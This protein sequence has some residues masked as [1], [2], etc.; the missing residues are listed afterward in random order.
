MGQ[1]LEPARRRP[2]TLTA[3]ELLLGQRAPELVDRS[4]RMRRTS[5]PGG[6]GIAPDAARRRS[7]AGVLPVHEHV[8]AV[9]GPRRRTRGRVTTRRRVERSEPA[10]P[11]QPAPVMGADDALDRVAELGDA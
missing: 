5:L 8:D 4:R 6:R 9:S 3:G 2:A 7:R 11:P 10:E 1:S